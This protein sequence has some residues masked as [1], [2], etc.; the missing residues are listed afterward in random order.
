MAD[1]SDLTPFNMD[2]NDE[3]LGKL[4]PPIDS[5]ASVPP[6][7]ETAI[8]EEAKLT[9]PG[10]KK[11]RHDYDGKSAER[12]RNQTLCGN[13]F[14]FVVARGLHKHASGSTATKDMWQNAW[15][16]AHNHLLH[17][18]VWPLLGVITSTPFEPYKKIIDGS[19]KMRALVFDAAAHFAL[20]YDEEENASHVLGEAFLP[21]MRQELGKQIISEQDDAIR[22]KKEKSAAKNSAKEKE[23]AENMAAE[24][25]LGLVSSRG[26]SAPSGIDMNNN[27]LEG[28]AG[29]GTHTSSHTSELLYGIYIFMC[30]MYVL[31][32]VICILTT[33][34]RVRLSITDRRDINPRTSYNEDAIDIDADV[35]YVPPASTATTATPKKGTTRPKKRKPQYHKDLNQAKAD[36]EDAA[37]G[38]VEN[39]NGKKK[40][41]TTPRN[42]EHVDGLDKLTKEM[43]SNGQV[44]KSLVVT[45]E[46]A[47][48]E[49]SSHH[50]N[51]PS[52]KNMDKVLKYQDHLSKLR[53]AKKTMIADGDPEEDI[54]DLT[55]EI[56]MYTKL[57]K[58]LNTELLAA[59]NV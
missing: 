27:I 47:L 49:S 57:K 3:S 29:L 4:S 50:T 51:S 53:A 11:I 10:K 43:A 2:I 32:C 25:H 21:D 56:K 15:E 59:A 8:A 13:L 16:Q 17:P 1:L 26:V 12:L 14:E 36:A 23:T 5:R 20:K 24:K 34:N 54:A 55:E 22:E 37:H 45:L 31:S 48:Q 7:L 30:L 58:N 35:E 33:T 6:L 41:A 46:Q 42:E 39:M 44:T 18:K 52:S 38:S 28:L 9:L 19:N 40:R